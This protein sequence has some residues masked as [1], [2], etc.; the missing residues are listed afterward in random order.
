[1]LHA[2]SEH[3]RTAP[4]CGWSTR[5]IPKVQGDVAAWFGAVPTVRQ[6]ARATNLLTDEGCA[7]NGFDELRQDQVLED[8]DHQ[9]RAGECVPYHRWVSDYI[10]V[11]GG[12]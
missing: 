3:I 8:P 1:M 12:R 4:I 5:S 10:G 11:I 2:E 9:V 7:T 6:P